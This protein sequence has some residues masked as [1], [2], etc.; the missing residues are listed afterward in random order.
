VGVLELV[1]AVKLEDSPL[2]S[3]KLGRKEVWGDGC[4][5]LS[6]DTFRHNLFVL[7]DQREVKVGCM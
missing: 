4:D 1:L 3:Q 5:F 6:S 7:T 2:I